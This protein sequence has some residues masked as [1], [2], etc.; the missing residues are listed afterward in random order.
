MTAIA[1]RRSVVLVLAF[2]SLILVAPT[3][4]PYDP[5]GGANVPSTAYQ[6]PS[7]K[8]VMG[9]DR[10]DRDVFSRVLRG[11]QKSVE[12]ALG[13]TGI[14]LV[15]GTG[16]ALAAGMFGGV[17]D[18]AMQRLT[19]I[20]LAVPRFL[21][22]F[23]VTAVT[24]HPLGTMQLIVLIG[25]TGWFDIAR[26]VRG[27]VSAIMSRDW[28]LATG[29]IGVGRIRLALH[30]IFPHLVPM[31][32]VMGTLAIGRTIVLE[33]GLSFLGAGSSGSSLG[34]LLNTGWDNMSPKWWLVVFPGLAI[35]L[36]VLT[37]NALGEALRDV[38]APEQVHAWPTT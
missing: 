35:V 3:F 28:V 33:A 17:V 30:H 36:I 22:L 5:D 7:L 9:T 8:H 14:A 16:F 31:L 29:A 4:A 18:T 10:L 19:D 24:E 25:L 12:I 26:I 13:A 38:F 27:E 20:T 11:S 37:C 15:V 34:N 2:L 23:A 1:T 6:E 21:L 32:I